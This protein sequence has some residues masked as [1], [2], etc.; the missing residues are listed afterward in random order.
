MWCWEDLLLKTD[1]LSKYKKLYLSGDTG[2]GFRSYMMATYLSFMQ[3]QH[4]KEV[5]VHHLCP[6]HAYNICDPAGGRYERQ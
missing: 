3:D 1:H 6:R 5:E 2:S 4:G